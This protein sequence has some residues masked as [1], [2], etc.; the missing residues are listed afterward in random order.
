MSMRRALVALLIAGTFLH[1]APSAAD[2][3]GAQTAAAPAVP[4]VRTLDNGL[5]VAFFPDSKL[6][7]VEIVLLV[8]AGTAVADSE[9]AALAW[10]TAEL[11]SHGTSSRSAAAFS[12]AL[13]GLG[14]TFSSQ[15]TREHAIVAATFVARDFA[16]GIELV[17]EAV[18]HP[19]FTASEVERVRRQ[20]GS[21]AVRLQQS[22][23]GQ[24][25]RRLWAE[26]FP[27]HPYGGPPFP[28]VGDV[29]A[30]TPERVLDFHARTYD[31]AGS[32][33][34][35]G[36]DV[37]AEQAFAAAREWFGGWSAAGAAAGPPDTGIPVPA[38][39]RPR[40]V[41]VDRPGWD[42][43]ELRL[44]FRVPARGA[45][46]EPAATLAA[47]ILS[48]G[49]E[50]R[51]GALERSGAFA[52]GVRA[53]RV[54]LGAAGFV[55]IGGN[56]PADSVAGALRSLRAAVAGLSTRPAGQAELQTAR[57]LERF[58]VRL[59]N[60]TLRD[61]LTRWCMG[62]LQGLPAGYE[63]AFVT[64]LARAGAD[65]VTTAARRWF[66]PARAVIV[67]VGP[68]ESMVGALGALGEVEAFTADGA[69]LPRGLLPFAE[70]PAPEAIA[71]GRELAQQALAAH[72]GLAKLRGIEDSTVESEVLLFASGREL[73]GRIR[74]V[75]KEPYRMQFMTWLG[76]LET[77][78]VLNGSHAWGID[79]MGEGGTFDLDAVQ[80]AALREGFAS[81]PHHM[82]LGLAAEGVE[83]V[84]LGRARMDDRDVDVLAVRDA[85]GDRWVAYLET[86]SHR[87][88]GVDSREPA[89]SGASIL[90]RIYR[91]YRP[92]KGIQ[93]PH[94]EDRMRAGTLLM[95]TFAT[96][97]AINSGVEDALFEK[98][99]APEPL[100]PAPRR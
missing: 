86:G 71:R 64:G 52:S 75:R 95:R 68:A 50:P 34:A 18:T 39:S 15:A 30:L 35:I 93:W 6:P 16:A 59:R 91:D 13:E 4:E 10:P 60:E 96:E 5:R 66:D 73:S 77:R 47:S 100:E 63:D 41:V 58:A 33:L 9:A 85:D 32:V 36:G 80:V 46:D 53:N 61:R 89:A 55:S 97:V 83:T 17:S 20:A 82:L 19:A 43:A 90:R 27:A 81:D 37:S 45:A 21:S 1:A 49:P 14:A 87:L 40:I 26:A 98:P 44:G 29:R 69:V 62:A 51:L 25:E 88:A 12:A 48:E 22:P 7:I 11:L 57:R 3:T 42:R 54:A 74:Q 76:G 78:Q 23:S 31:P 2:A 38:D 70:P 56:V 94:G 72:G 84:S 8:P 28:E 67:A 92:V 79:T 24:A 99:V 65:D